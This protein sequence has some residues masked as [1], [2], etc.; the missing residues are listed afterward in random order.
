M[1]MTSLVAESITSLLYWSLISRY[2][3]MS[4]SLSEG[5]RE[6]NASRYLLLGIRTDNLE[7]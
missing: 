5:L 3:S 1:P 2:T 4:F 6:M 7:S